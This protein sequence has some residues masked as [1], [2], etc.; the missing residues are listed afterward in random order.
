MKDRGI[1]MG[2]F[3]KGIFENDIALDVKDRFLELFS[4]GKTAI[5]INETMLK[6]FSNEMNDT[7]DSIPF[8]LALADIEWQHGILFPD[9]KTKALKCLEDI[10][11][12][13]LLE[14]ENANFT[15]S[16]TKVLDKLREKLNS[17]QPKH[18]KYKTKTPY[19]CEWKSGD[20]FAFQLESNLSIEKGLSGQY[21][22][23][24]KVDEG[25]WHPEHIIPIVYVKITKDGRIPTSISEFDQCE[26]IQTSF[27]F[28]EE[29]FWPIDGSRSE[30]DIAEKSKLVYEVDE[31]GY[32]PQFRIALVNSSMR[33]IPKKLLYVGNFIDT[34]TPTK[35]F[36]PHS[37][38]NIAAVLW[39]NFEEI[40]IDRYF[41]HNRRQSKIYH[42]M[43]N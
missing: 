43:D 27:S 32:L 35:E 4:E 37:K 19:K 28:F 14:V 2:T 36:I 18:K 5:E 11:T 31:F 8:W 9:V 16:R 10:K 6:E 29:R 1:N 39:K 38:I 40:L 42:R 17:P 24:Q 25:L 15:S 20:V 12:Q 33:I 26:Y 21:L 13:S 22:L 41:R 23:V 7:D 30:E 3:G 34:I